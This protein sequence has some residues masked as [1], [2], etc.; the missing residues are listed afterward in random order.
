MKC[1]H[2]CE[3]CDETWE[4]SFPYYSNF[5]YFKQTIE[6]GYY[7]NAYCPSCQSE[8][9]EEVD[10]LFKNMAEKGYMKPSIRV[11]N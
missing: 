6:N 4:C 11:P 7:C 9:R 5:Q 10:N 8:K 1:K 3:K 2:K